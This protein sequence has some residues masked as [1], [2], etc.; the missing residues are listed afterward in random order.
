MIF[1]QL[2]KKEP[3]NFYLSYPLGVSA[4][5]SFIPNKFMFFANYMHRIFFHG[6]FLLL[7]FTSKQPAAGDGL[8]R[9]RNKRVQDTLRDV[10]RLSSLTDWLNEI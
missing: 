7:T 9:V 3:N 1:A 6:Q 2:F 5:E 4:T 10:V 8:N